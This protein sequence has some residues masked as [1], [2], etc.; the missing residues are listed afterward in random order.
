METVEHSIE[1]KVPVRDVY[2]QW[3]DIE[4]Y[5]GFLE[6]VERVDPVSE[7][8]THWVTGFGGHRREFDVE[9][10]ERV[11]GQKVAW[12]SVD[13]PSYKG[14]VSLRELPEG[15]TEVALRIDAEP[16][17]D[18][19]EEWTALRVSSQVKG[20]LGRFKDYIEIRHGETSGRKGP[21]F[22]PTGRGGG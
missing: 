21:M 14:T 8:R 10:T 16:T 17:A 13:G 20:D 18:A 7:N 3:A 2:E 22:P 19:G 4:S 6:G 15:R 9:A 11:P 12:Q 1:V 5:P